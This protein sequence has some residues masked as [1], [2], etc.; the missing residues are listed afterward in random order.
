MKRILCLLLILSVLLCTAC[1]PAP[2]VPDD[3]PQPDPVPDAPKDPVPQPTPEPVPDPEPAPDPEPT[4]DPKP[5][6]PIPQRRPV[7]IFHGET[8]VAV[9]SQGNIIL[10]GEADSLSLLYDSAT[11]EI[12]C[13]QETLREGMITDQW[14]W[15]EP[16][17][18]WCRLYDL[19]GNLLLEPE[20]PYVSVCGDF[21]SYYDSKTNDFTVLKL[22][23][24][25]VLVEQ[26]G[27]AWLAG[28][29]IVVKDLQWEQPST[30]LDA[31][32]KVLWQQTEGWYISGYQKHGEQ[33]YLLVVN[34]DGLTGLATPYGDMLL[35]CEYLEIGDITGNRVAADTGKGWV[36]VD[37]TT[38]ETLLQWPTRIMTLLENSLIAAESQDYGRFFLMDYNGQRLSDRV[39]Q[40]LNPVDDDFDD[41]PELLYGNLDYSQE[42]RPEDVSW[43]QQ[44]VVFLRPDGTELYC[45][46]Y[47]TS[48]LE[49]MDSRVILRRDGDWGSE[50][51]AY[52]IQHLETGEK[53]EIPVKSIIFTELLWLYSGEDPMDRQYFTAYYQNPL[54]HSRTCVVD[55]QGNI[56]LDDLK[57]CIYLG[58]GVF[59]VTVGFETGLMDLNGNWLLRQ[60]QFTGLRD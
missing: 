45:E 32:G 12:A 23:D 33:F 55:Q 57:S 41:I 20:A 50:N 43:E 53:I 1:T 60:S 18:S 6:R 4:P 19:Q 46:E 3:P 9:D 15:A 30:I 8:D 5:D 38:G 22:S 35:P 42:I 59:Q 34:P 7:Y 25:S 28:D 14:G 10:Q 13:I 24:G 11:G 27:M 17:R 29:V 31:D 16:E 26:A 58:G 36:V 21:V 52:A 39:F 54:G 49:P 51:T 2:P 44:T 48:Q 56:L 37:L 40:W 47:T